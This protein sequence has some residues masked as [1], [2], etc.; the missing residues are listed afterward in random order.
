MHIILSETFIKIVS[1]QHFEISAY[2][3]AKNPS[4]NIYLNANFF[5]LMRNI[6]TLMTRAF[7]SEF[8]CIFWKLNIDNIYTEMY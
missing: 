5:K 4:Y 6:H 2:E 3:P 7:Q 8:Y 1:L